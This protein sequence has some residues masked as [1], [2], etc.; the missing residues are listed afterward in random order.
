[1]TLFVTLNM[2]NGIL[3]HRPIVA[4]ISRCIPV[5]QPHPYAP[6]IEKLVRHVHPGL[7]PPTQTAPFSL[8][9]QNETVETSETNETL[10]LKS[11]QV[12]HLACAKERGIPPISKKCNFLMH[13]PKMRQSPL[14]TQARRLQAPRTLAVASP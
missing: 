10:F 8:T 3:F 11:P 4:K 1:M 14:E 7:R 12:R 9:S 2:I 5:Y 6:F 13:F